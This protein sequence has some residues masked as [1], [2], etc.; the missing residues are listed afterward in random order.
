MTNG[1]GIISFG[2]Y[3][4]RRRLQRQTVY[5]ANAW[6]AAG[7]KGLSE[8]E[9]AIANWDE[10]PITMAVEAAR[11][12]LTGVER[13]TV[14]AIILA[15]TTPPYLDR[16]NAGLVKE[17]LTLADATAALDVTGSQRSAT[18]ALTQSLKV[19][20]SDGA[21][22]LVLA[23]ELRKA[24]PASE[25]ELTNGDGAAG[26]LVGSGDAVVARLIGTHSVTFDF[27][28]HYRTPD[29]AFDYGW[30]SRWI[31]DEGYAGILAGAL[32]GGLAKLG[33]DGSAV[34]RLI[35]P[36]AARGVPEM[37]ARRAGIPAAA[38]ADTLSRHVGDTGAAHPI[39]MLCH[40]LETAKPGDLVVV[41]SFGQGADVLVFEVT[42]AIA[43]LPARRGVSGSIAR[44]VA[45]TNYL[46]YLFHRGLLDLER[47][48]RAEAD[49]KQPATT[50]WRSRKAVL[51][52]VGGRCTKTGTIQ[53]PRTEIA[54]DSNAAH[55]QEDYPL[56]ERRAKILTFTADS[57]TYSAAPPSYYGMIDFEGGGRMLT[58]FADLEAQD[59]EVGREVEM[60]FR[61]KGI[62]DR[63]DFTKYF[64]KAVPVAR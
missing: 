39:L 34:N 53:F 41:T 33:I 11:D 57:L 52:L 48:M 2:A 15:S 1:V 54:V 51:G 29:M 50:L 24:R 10:D 9:R 63:R 49:Q 8:G 21:P 3:L 38:V 32:V 12:T 45:D 14:S 47:G 43:A 40:V 31:R 25:A 23:S 62:D 46:R 18:S 7:L 30:E 55:E 28:D 13:S 44:G 17:A 16:L 37:L 59:I 6:F 27:V 22:Q 61:I 35:V 56:A 19:A 5:Q 4:P 36:V 20:G 64:W 60:M 42:D 26:L 58:E